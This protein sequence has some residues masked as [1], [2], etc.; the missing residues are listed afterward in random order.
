MQLPKEMAIRALTAG[1][2]SDNLASTE[3]HLT[4]PTHRGPSGLNN[5]EPLK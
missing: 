3:T 2:D 1:A 5:K 4:H